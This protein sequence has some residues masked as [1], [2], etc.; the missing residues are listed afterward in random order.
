M[1]KKR[2]SIVKKI[3]ENR[4]V[5]RFG[6]IIAVILAVVCLGSAL[7]E[8]VF[9]AKV[10]IEGFDKKYIEVSNGTRDALESELEQFVYL[11]TV[12]IRVMLVLSCVRIAMGRLMRMKMAIKAPLSI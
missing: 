1:A 5:R 3:A 11:N 4:K 12:R 2:K 6:I 7:F 8:N 10:S 9:R